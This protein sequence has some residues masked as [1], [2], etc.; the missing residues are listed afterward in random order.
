MTDCSFGTPTTSFSN[1]TNL[2]IAN[3]KYKLIVANKNLDPSQQ[4]IYTPSGIIYRDNTSKISGVTSL[5]LSPVSASNP[6]TFTLDI[7]APNGNLVGV[8]GKLWRDT[9]NT[10]TVT[11]SGL[12]I[13]PSVYTASGSLSADETFSV[14]G[15]NTSGTD[16]FLTLTISVTGASGNM[17]VD[18]VSAPQAAAI[19]FGEF[20]YWARGLP[21]SV[22]AASF[23]SAGDVWNYL[24][25]N[26]STTGSIG[27]FVKKLLT[28]AKFLGLK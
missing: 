7:P 23:V 4:E 13:T 17:W 2:A 6:L 27:V 24:S 15:T 12:G 1:L 28:V 26:I 10:A 16:G 20:G 9:A 18:A 21:A 3:S 11:L 14:Q 5:K 25:A 19:D 22:V 8:S